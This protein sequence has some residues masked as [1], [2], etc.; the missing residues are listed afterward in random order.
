VP[1][2]RTVPDAHI[3]RPAAMLP[4]EQR[5]YGIQIGKDYPAP[6]VDHAEQREHI[7]ALYAAARRI[8]T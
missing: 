6:I 5:Q 2:L 7:M 8:G 3:H 4:M 1:E